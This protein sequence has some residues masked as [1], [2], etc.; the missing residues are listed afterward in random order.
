MAIPV[1]ILWWISTLVPMRSAT[2]L[3]SRIQAS[4]T[5]ICP[6]VLTKHSRISQGKR[7]STLCVA[8]STGLS[9]RIFLNPPVVY[10]ISISR[11]VMAAR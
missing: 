6:V 9:A 3:L 11:H 8:M 7:Q 5:E 1:S 2:V 10:V 4:F